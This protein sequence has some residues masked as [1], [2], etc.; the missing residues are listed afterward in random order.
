MLAKATRSLAICSD[1]SERR[2][3]ELNG[4]ARLKPAAIAAGESFR[5]LFVSA[6]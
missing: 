2:G 6:G 1:F 3:R 5:T 4:K